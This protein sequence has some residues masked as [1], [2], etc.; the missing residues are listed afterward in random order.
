MQRHI[1]SIIIWDYFSLALQFLEQFHKNRLL[2]LQYDLV[3]ATHKKKSSSKFYGD[4]EGSRG[5]AKREIYFN[6]K[7]K[8]HCNRPLCIPCLSTFQFIHILLC[9]N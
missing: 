8:Q 6:Y 3:R 5:I 4:V 9:P 7:E 2:T 1:I